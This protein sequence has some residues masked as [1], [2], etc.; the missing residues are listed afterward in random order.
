MDVAAGRERFRCLRENVS[1]VVRE[2]NGILDKLQPQERSHLSNLM[3]RGSWAALAAMYPITKL[4][5]GP[6]LALPRT[7]P[8]RQAPDDTTNCTPKR[9]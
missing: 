8:A 9:R 2:Y 6:S 3:P 5:Q 7:S 1:L 4:P